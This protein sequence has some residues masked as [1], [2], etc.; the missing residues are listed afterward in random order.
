[1]EESDWRQAKQPWSMPFFITGGGDGS[2]SRGRMSPWQVKLCAWCSASRLHVR[3]HLARRPVTSAE[4]TLA[5]SSVVRRRTCQ[6]GSKR[7]PGGGSYGELM[8]N[9]LVPS[10]I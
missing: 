2:P 4:A 8:E 3:H 5:T 6:Q 9:L 7:R 1:M 10:P